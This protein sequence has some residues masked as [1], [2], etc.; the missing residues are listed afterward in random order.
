MCFSKGPMDLMVVPSC[1]FLSW[2]IIWPFGRRASWSRF[3]LWLKKIMYTYNYIWKFVFFF[4]Q[5]PSLCYPQ[6][7]PIVFKCPIYHGR[8]MI[9]PTSKSSAPWK[10]SR[11]WVDHHSKTICQKGPTYMTPN[12]TPIFIESTLILFSLCK[13]LELKTQCIISY[14]LSL[15]TCHVLGTNPHT[16]TS[17]TSNGN[18]GFL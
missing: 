5:F 15:I 3:K 2:I 10:A 14:K 6:L 7:F 4:H 16:R 1:K 13:Y 8:N 12:S 9:E 11:Q 18:V 17:Y